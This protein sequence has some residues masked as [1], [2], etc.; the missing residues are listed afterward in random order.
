[1]LAKRLI[2]P[3]GAVE[4]GC[5]V[6]SDVGRVTQMRINIFEQQN[7][8]FHIFEEIGVVFSLSNNSGNRLRISIIALTPMI[9]VLL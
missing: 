4:R 2:W 8:N 5:P 6:D 9:N 1:M 3:L 7:D